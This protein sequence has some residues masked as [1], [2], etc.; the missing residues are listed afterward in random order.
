[1]S[2]TLVRAPKVPPVKVILVASKVLGAV[3]KVKVT[4]AVSPTLKKDLLLVMATPGAVEAV[5]SSDAAAPKLPAA[6]K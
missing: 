6:S 1:M 5:R 4:S 3:E 2:E